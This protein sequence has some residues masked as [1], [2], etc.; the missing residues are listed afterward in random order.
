MVQAATLPEAYPEASFRP[1]DGAVE[2]AVAEAAA[3]LEPR[4]AKVTALLAAAYAAVGHVPATPAALR[5]LCSA[6][7]EWLVHRAAIRFAGAD[8]WFVTD[9]THCGAPFDLHVPLASLPRSAPGPGFPVTRVETKLGV[10]HFE[11]PNGAHEEAF[12]VMATADPR[13]AFAGLCGLEPD[14]AEAAAR[15]DTDDLALIDAALEA[16]SP[17][18]ADSVDATC[19][20]CGAANAARLD[21]FVFAFPAPATVLEDVHRI[22][23][24]YGWGEADILALPSDRRRA[25]VRL[26][27]RDRPTVVG[28][29]STREQ[30]Q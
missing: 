17:D 7:R 21:P 9:C 18:V 19:P 24:A 30:L 16:L 23:G 5:R 3:R 27:R 2:I 20:E 28:R 11:T 22:A 4:P 25:Y 12:A 8:G 6:G 10:R 13:R 1:L 15:F 26:I 29:G 14:A